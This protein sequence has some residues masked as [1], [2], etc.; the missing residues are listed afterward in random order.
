MFSAQCKDSPSLFSRSRC[1]FPPQS[2][3]YR[4][5]ADIP[6]VEPNRSSA[7][8][9]VI[10]VDVFVCRSY[11]VTLLPWLL[12]TQSREVRCVHS[13]AFF[14]GA[15]LS[16]IDFSPKINWSIIKLHKSERRSVVFLDE[17]A[18]R[19]FPSAGRVFFR[20]EDSLFFVKPRK[21]RL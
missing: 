2:H 5:S 21:Y 20:P 8:L 14:S 18:V 6:F 12:L 17:A 19:L 11:N 9:H 1:Y 4:L 15:K 16:L 7:L 3:R 13:A 10:P